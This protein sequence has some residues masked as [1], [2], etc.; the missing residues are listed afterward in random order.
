MRKL[1]LL[2]TAV[3]V[4][5]G[6][7]GCGSDS[8]DEPKVDLSQLDVGNY[9]TK[10]QDLGK[11]KDL[12]QARLI[13]AARLAS[14]VPLPM[15][16]DSSLRFEPPG[17]AVRTFIDPESAALDGRA[18]I[19]RD[20]FAQDAK[21]FMFGFTGT[22]MSDKVEKLA[23]QLDTV[24]MVFTDDEAAKY[25]ARAL[26]ERENARD[27]D[28]QPAAL[29]KYPEAYTFW[30]PKYSSLLSW[31]ATGRFVIFST[32]W[33]HVGMATGFGDES[34]LTTLAEKNLDIVPNRLKG[35]TPTPDDKWAEV[36][37]DI[38]GMLGRTVPSLNAGTDRLGDPAV[39]DGHSGLHISSQPGEDEKLFDDLGVDKVAFNGGLLYRTRNAAA[40]RRLVDAHAKV[41]KLFRPTAAPKGLPQAKCSEYH[42]LREQRVRFDCSIAVGRYAAEIWANQRA[43]AY[44]RIS[45]QYAL[46]ANSN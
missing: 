23:L 45:A 18:V 19:H 24:V 17:S 43:D 12:N 38:D 20:L 1:A 14:Y 29:P 16:I 28:N 2:M 34:I 10:P 7:V 13:D 11:A 22:G 6:A 9:P 15:E 35:F 5:V 4:L 30:Q 27:S 44:Q 32:V 26:G 42:G 46:L 37:A 33:D 8:D 36:P 21:G 31:F 40:A 39:Y 3:T 41:G 25:A